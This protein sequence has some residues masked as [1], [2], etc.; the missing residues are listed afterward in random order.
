MPSTSDRARVTAPA[1]DMTDQSAG[2]LRQFLVFEK[3]CEL[4]QR[5]SVAGEGLASYLTIPAVAPV[6]KLFHSDSTSMKSRGPSPAP[7][8]RERSRLSEA[9][10]NRPLPRGAST[11]LVRL[12]A[13]GLVEALYPVDRRADAHP[14]LDRRLMFRSAP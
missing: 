13:A 6:M 1:D 4:D 9:A 5:D 7:T 10:S 3:R 8:R 12:D 14:K 2:D 11:D